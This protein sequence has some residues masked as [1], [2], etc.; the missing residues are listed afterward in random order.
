MDT[1]CYKCGAGIQDGTAFCPSC[2]APQIRVNVPQP[3][4]TVGSPSFAPGTPAEMQPPA[5]PV[6]LGAIIA[7]PSGVDWGAA[8]NGVLVAGLLMGVVSALTGLLGFILV[9]GGGAAAVSRYQRKRGIGTS[10]GDGAKIGA[11][12]GILGYIVFAV[13]AGVEYVAKPAMIRDALVQAIQH[14]QTQN[15]NPATQELYQKFMTPEGLAVLIVVSM[16]IFFVGFIALS[17]IGGML[18]AA[19][20]RREQPRL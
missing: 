9:I 7:P 10:T 2:G 8:R 6:N 1:T 13:I 11:L 3:P 15:P 19:V 12:S 4:Q 16:A 20:S 14:A 18:T 17:S 5:Q